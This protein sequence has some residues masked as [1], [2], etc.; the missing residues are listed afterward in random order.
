MVSTFQRIAGTAANLAGRATLAHRF[1]WNREADMLLIAA[2]QP[3][4][5]RQSGP[6]AARRAAV[7]RALT[8]DRSGGYARE[9]VRSPFAPRSFPLNRFP[10]SNRALAPSNR[11][12]HTRA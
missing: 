9:R 6:C 10:R 3:Q 11:K 5:R 4:R 2:S 7:A 12:R 1:S 8:D